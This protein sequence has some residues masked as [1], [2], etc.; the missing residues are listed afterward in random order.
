MSEFWSECGILEGGS[1]PNSPLNILSLRGEDMNEKYDIWEKDAPQRQAELEK[2]LTKRGEKDV[3]T[4][5]MTVALAFPT[6][7]PH[8]S[9]FDYPR[10]NE[11]LLRAWASDRGWKVQTAPEMEPGNDSASP[12]IR[13]TRV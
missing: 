6:R 4:H 5:Y 3:V 13:F 12:P 2:E 1:V 10:I 9:T 7:T 11:S 8:P